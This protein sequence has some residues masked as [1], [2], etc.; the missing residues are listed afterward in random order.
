MIP[1]IWDSHFAGHTP[2]STLLESFTRMPA[3]NYASSLSAEPLKSQELIESCYK[4]PKVLP[5]SSPG[6]IAIARA[7][8]RT[9][10]K[11]PRCAVYGTCKHKFC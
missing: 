11:C 2:P 10:L 9:C 7:H 5:L 6:N 3:N 4:E 8:L 1:D